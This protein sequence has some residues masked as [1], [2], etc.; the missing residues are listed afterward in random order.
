M[1]S[2]DL[3]GLRTWRANIHYGKRLHSQGRESSLRTEIRLQFSGLSLL[4]AVRL[5][6]SGVSM[7]NGAHGKV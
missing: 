6:A 1:V 3:N 2:R 4:Y 5:K 7:Q